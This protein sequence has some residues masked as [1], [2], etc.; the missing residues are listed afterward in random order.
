MAES[1]LANLIGEPVPPA[2][3]DGVKAFS[4]QL[5]KNA[6]LAD[7]QIPQ[8]SSQVFNDLNSMKKEFGTGVCTLVAIANM[9]GADMRIVRLQ[10][11][12]GHIWKYPPPPSIGPGQVGVFLHGKT[13]LATKG[14]KCACIYKAKVPNE[15]EIFVRLAFDSGFN[16][17]NHRR[18]HAD[19]QFDD[20]NWPELSSE[21][22]GSSVSVKTF[23][24]TADDITGKLEIKGT[25]G[26][27]YSPICQFYVGYPSEVIEECKKKEI[28]RK[29]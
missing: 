18:V 4:D 20:K 3:K 12:H 8:L 13:K 1:T 17:F 10:D 19:A 23:P 29:I 26:Q 5:I 28:E 9:T 16:R 7:M 27:S 11:F 24:E 21:D 22:E 6:V 2:V 14:S 25:I 15:Q